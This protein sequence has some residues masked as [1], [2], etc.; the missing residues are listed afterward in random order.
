MTQYQIIEQDRNRGINMNR[1]K[2]IIVNK[3]PEALRVAAGS[4]RIST[5]QGTAM[6]IYGRSL[7]DEKDLSL[8]NKVLASGH[9]S[10]I[11]HQ[12][13]SIAFDNV[14]VLVEQFV[15]ECRLASF[16]VKSRRYV[17]FGEAGWVC[18]E[19][20]DAGQRAIYDA[21]MAARFED[22]KRLMALGVPKE[23]ARFVLPYSLRSNFFMTVNAR[24]LI[25]LICA[26][27]YGRGKGFAE[28]ESL[29]RQLKAQFDEMFPGVIDAEAARYSAFEPLPVPGRIDAGT[30]R[31]GDAD[32]I[33]SPRDAEDLLGAALAFSG[34]FA[35]KCFPDARR[36]NLRS[37]LTD[38]RP[39]ELEVLN[40]TFHIRRV[41]LACV[42][43]FTRHRMVSLMV[44]PVVTGLCGGDYVLPETVKALPEAETIYRNAFMA[45][46]SAAADAMGAGL[47]MPQLAYFAMSGHE[48]D[49]LLTV[50]ARELVHFMKLR[51][52]RRA[53][54]EIR[55]VAW[56]MLDE[57]RQSCPEIFGHIGP[58]CV[59]GKCPEG[60]MS[61]GRPYKSIWE[62]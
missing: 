5:Q 58:S 2:A 24:E 56:R 14:S 55:G 44:P 27:L 25:A 18:P 7:G 17:D 60:R 32:L 10:V 23:D 22:Y 9:K 37:L 13:V 51:T 29:G 38:A 35:P 39:R 43:H 16:T 11:E 30:D 50:N 1:S 26:M 54:W 62:E 19:G 52:C 57:L 49:L 47:P 4:A 36:D 8:M 20:L 21:A 6:E 33:A 3:N 61:C 46:H 31:P 40:Y 41:S 53:Q 48:I 34:R 12:T 42:T 45:Q 59:Y 15:I 28:I